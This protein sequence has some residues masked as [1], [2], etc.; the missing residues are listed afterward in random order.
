M[1]KTLVQKFMERPCI[2]LDENSSV[3][4]LADTLNKNRVGGFVITS[5][6]TNFPVA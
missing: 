6:N 3:K 5:L 1:S 2:T 4:N